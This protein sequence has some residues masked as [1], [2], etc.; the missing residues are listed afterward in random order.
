MHYGMSGLI[1]FIETVDAVEDADAIASVS[2]GL[3]YGHAD[4]EAELY[5]ANQ[6]YLEIAQA[7]LCVAAAKYRIPAIDTSSLEIDDMSVVEAHCTSARSNGFTGKAAIHPRQVPVINRV[8]VMPAETLA[9]YERTVTDYQQQ[10]SGFRIIDNR[11]IAP[12]FVAK[13]RLM[14]ESYRRKQDRLGP[15]HRRA[16]TR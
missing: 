14:I 8:F 3:C 7:R 15:A 13:A 4:L 2:D 16:G 5:S 11:V 9:D 6:T 10:D 12:P 1:S